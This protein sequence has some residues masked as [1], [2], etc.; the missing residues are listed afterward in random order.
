MISQERASNYFATICA[1]ST[2]PRGQMRA[3]LLSVAAGKEP[4]TDQPMS[5][6]CQF[7]SCGAANR[8]L[9]DHRIGSGE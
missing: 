6:E 3:E 2:S 7:G 8:R 5:E 1:C 4:W 9:F